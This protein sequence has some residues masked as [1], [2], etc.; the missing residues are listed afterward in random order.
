MCG[1][2]ENSQQHW[3]VA[4]SM[5]SYINFPDASFSG[6][7]VIHILP[8]MNS[9]SLPCRH[10]RPPR[11]ASDKTGDL[12]LSRICDHPPL[13]PYANLSLRTADAAPISALPRQK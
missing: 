11:F 10:P 1:A 3:N 7:P 8:T 2:G 12:P 9:S 13:D 6:R 5:Y 4:A